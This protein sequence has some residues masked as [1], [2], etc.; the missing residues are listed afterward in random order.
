MRDHTLR[1]EAFVKLGTF[2]K[3]FCIYTNKDNASPEYSSELYNTLE[4]SITLAKYKNGWFTRENIL[5]SIE[6]WGNALSKE[7]WP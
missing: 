1:I 3:E 6:N 2:F 5:F 7:P 4:S